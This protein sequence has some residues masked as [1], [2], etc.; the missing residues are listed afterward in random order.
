[1]RRKKI[2]MNEEHVMDPVVFLNAIEHLSKEKN[3]DK[4]II[5]EAMQNGFASAYRRNYNS[6]ANVKVD[7]D[8][9]TGAL[10]V[11]AYRTVVEE[12]EDEEKEILLEEAMELIPDITVGENIYEEVTPSDFG[13]VAISTAKQVVVQRLKE[14]EKES[15]LAE[16]GDK[17][18]EL[19][20]GK[21]E[22]EDENNYMIDLGRIHGLLPKNELMGNE[23]I[24]MGSSI[25]VFV[26]KI[27]TA[28]RSP[29]IL[30]SRKHY[31]FVKKLLELEIPEVASGE[32]IVHSVAREAGYRTKIAVSSTVENIEAVGTCIGEK[33]NRIERVIKELGGEKIDVILYDE[34][35][36]KFIENAL[37]PAKIIR[38]IFNDEEMNTAV[39]VVDSDNF[40]LAIGRKGQNVKLAARLTK[41][42]IDIK[43]LDEFCNGQ[44][45]VNESSN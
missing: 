32:I 45:V 17:T 25:K 5:V 23:K 34:D 37:S 19:L 38:V 44:E 29:L 22:R 15:I 39:A 31:G 13:R 4:E 1:M 20:L 11:K 14:A 12:L 6:E 27:E 35:K 18:Y 10:T 16:F 43:T 3:I 26:S 7:I 2:D 24:E 42:R 9:N 41:S 33:G 30:L 36:A 21:V 40:T 28:G 8:M